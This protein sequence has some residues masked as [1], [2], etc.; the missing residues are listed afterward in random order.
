LGQLR[1]LGSCRRS[2]M[3]APIAP[4][5]PSS[6]EARRFFPACVGYI[7]GATIGAQ[8]QTA[9]EGLTWWMTTQLHG[10]TTTRTTTS[11]HFRCTCASSG[12]PMIYN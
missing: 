5:G 6:L 11:S 4:R 3:L 1:P 9:R 8:G 10:T 2:P 7:G 12:N